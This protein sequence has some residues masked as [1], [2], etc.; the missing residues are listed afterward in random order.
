MEL[1][2]AKLELAVFAAKVIGVLSS[3][4]HMFS[5]DWTQFDLTHGIRDKLV[6]FHSFNRVNDLDDIYTMRHK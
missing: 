2:T 3:K 1:R 4:K 6:S 5:L